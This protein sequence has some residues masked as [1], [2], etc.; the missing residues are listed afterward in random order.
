MVAGRVAAVRVAAA[1]EKAAEALV[2]P[3][4]AGVTAAEMVMVAE[5]R[6]KAGVTAGSW[7]E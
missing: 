5:D 1:T 4:A 3:V 6:A 7:V 2:V